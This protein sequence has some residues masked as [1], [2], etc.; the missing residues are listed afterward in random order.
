M[1]SALGQFPAVCNRQENI[2][3]KTCC[4]SNCGEGQGRGKCRN[5]TAEVISQWERADPV[6][7][8]IMKDA[9]TNP[10]KLAA[11]SR[12]LWPTV[13]FEY[14]CVCSGN[15]G[16]VDCSQCD[17]GWSG[18]N[19]NTPRTPVTR[20]GFGRL[21]SEEKQAFIRATL[22]L[23]NEMGYWS[24][25]VKEPVNYST[26]FVKLQNVTTYDFFV[27][28]HDFAARAHPESCFIANNRVTIDFAHNGPVFPVWHRYYLLIL[29]KEFQRIMGNDSFGL[30]YWQWEENDM[31]MFTSQ[32][33]GI[34]S[35]NRSTPAN[36]VSGDVINTENWHTVCDLEYRMP[37]LPNCSDYW[38]PCNPAEDLLEKHPLQRGGGSYY[39]PNTVEVKIA[40]SA[41]T[42]DSSNAAGSFGTDSP[43]SSFR[44]RMEGWSIICSA[45]NCTGSINRATVFNLHMRNTVHLWVGG[46]MACV[47]ASINDP[48]FNLHHCNVDRIL[49]SWL[50]R[51][52]NT[53]PNSELLTAYAPVRQG[54]P[55][56]NRGDYMVPFF[57]LMKA[58]HQYRIA[59]EFGYKY[60]QLVIADMEDSNIPDC[61]AIIMNSASC[62]ICGADGTCYNCTQDMTCPQPAAIP[63]T[64][65]DAPDPTSSQL[66][67]ELGLGLGLGLLLLLAI[68][69]ILY[70][71]IVVKLKTSAPDTRW[72]ILTAIIHVPFHLI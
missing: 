54:H 3:T 50:Q 7:T 67:L 31:S 28:L 43:R 35:H 10:Q 46:Q 27:F 8:G 47:P 2:Q 6:V 62:P 59:T 24:V 18:S 16:G 65:G 5:I 12:Y 29:E 1:E 25:I 49:E 17:F 60:D 21:S 51:Y 68:A 4:P 58:G 57:P 45:V 63:G 66:G 39:L 13:V 14:V 23:K 72:L 42:Y 30:P 9:P 53:L 36:N 71:V 38:K 33:Y 22:D 52:A 11:D 64:E 32:Y 40:I 20:K 61:S 19:C 26:G 69:I 55:G 70:F 41:P 37:R 56:H 15:Y 44:T 34:P 48:V